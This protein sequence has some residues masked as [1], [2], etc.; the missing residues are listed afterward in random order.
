MA[1][2][3]WTAALS[4]CGPSA[5]DRQ[6]AW[7]EYESITEKLKAEVDR[8]EA[9]LGVPEPE[10]L[11]EVKAK[12]ARATLN[13]DLSKLRT[14]PDKG[15]TGAAEHAEWAVWEPRDDARSEL[16]ALHRSNEAFRWACDRCVEEMNTER[17]ERSWDK[18]LPD[19]QLTLS[20]VNFYGF[21]MLGCLADK[22]D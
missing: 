7:A 3:A 11:A 12:L 13:L 17:E 20:N 2:F 21:D 6:K 1:L 5:D 15:S 18:S 22:L 10:S 16:L 19:V 4:A 14:H 8:R 9:T